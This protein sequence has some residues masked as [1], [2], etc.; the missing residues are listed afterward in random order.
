[1]RGIRESLVEKAL[2]MVGVASM[3]PPA[4]V[5]QVRSVMKPMAERQAAAIEIA[6]VRLARDAAGD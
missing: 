4:L 6:R 3:T 5:E 2:D 1:M